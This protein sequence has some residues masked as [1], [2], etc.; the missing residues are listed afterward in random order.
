MSGGG[1]E[2]E[3]RNVWTYSFIYALAVSLSLDA[4]A[5]DS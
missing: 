5:E 4:R 3:Q 1:S 2:Q